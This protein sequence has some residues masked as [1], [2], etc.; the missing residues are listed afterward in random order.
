MTEQEARENEKARSEAAAKVRSSI[1][2][3]HSD[4]MLLTLIA[5]IASP[6]GSDKD[7]AK[8]KME[9]ALDSFKQGFKLIEDILAGR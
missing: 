4:L 6:A 5:A 3:A 7:A 8:L 1:A 9:A 2:A